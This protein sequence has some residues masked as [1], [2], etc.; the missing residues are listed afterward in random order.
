MTYDIYFGGRVE[1]RK[2][3]GVEVSVWHPDEIVKA[4]AYDSPIPGYDTFNTINLRL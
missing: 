1:K 2:E 4:V 3:N